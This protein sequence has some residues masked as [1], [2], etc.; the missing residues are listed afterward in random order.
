MSATE[1]EKDPRRQPTVLESDTL[2]FSEHGRSANNVDFRSHWLTLVKAQYG[3]Y[4]LLV[5]HGGGEER[6]S[7]G[8]D[9][10]CN[11]LDALGQL[12]EDQR[13][14]I[15]YCLYD[16]HKDAKHEARE[17]RTSYFHLAFLEG[18]LKRRKRNHRVYCEVQPQAK[19]VAT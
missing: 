17:E 15:L 4:F 10:V 3:G 1:Y 6:I 19:E 5:K 2:I 16:A 11:A 9:H 18:R 13:Y 14:L 8:Y 12:T 7:L